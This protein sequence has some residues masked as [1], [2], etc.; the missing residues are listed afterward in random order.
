MEQITADKLLGMFDGETHDAIR[1]LAKTSTAEALVVFENLDMCSSSLGE[2][3]VLIVGPNQTFKSVDFCKGK[4]L[5]DL[6]SQRQYP[7][8]WAD[9]ADFMNGT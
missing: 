2:R 9:V 6:P 1:K 5:K 4:H 7:R 8:F 3:S